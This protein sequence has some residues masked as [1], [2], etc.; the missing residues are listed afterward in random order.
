MSPSVATNQQAF[1]CKAIMAS[2]KSH[3]CGQ[4]F[5]SNTTPAGVSPSEARLQPEEGPT[6]LAIIN[7]FM[8]WS[9][10]CLFKSLPT[11]ATAETQKLCSDISCDVIGAISSLGGMGSGPGQVQRFPCRR[12]VGTV[13]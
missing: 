11:S 6:K 7:M 3:R 13:V 2:F 5:I 8:E 1:V 12:R 10:G 4:V 9:Y